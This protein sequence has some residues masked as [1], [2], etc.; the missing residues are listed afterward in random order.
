MNTMAKKRPSS[1]KRP[2]E[3]EKPPGEKKPD[4]HRGVQIPFRVDDPR[5]IEQLDLYAEEVRRSRNM[6]IILLLE[7]I[8]KQ[9]GYWPPPPDTTSD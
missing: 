1:G 9:K 7:E 8:L 5:L 4:P 6:A 3:D 2:G